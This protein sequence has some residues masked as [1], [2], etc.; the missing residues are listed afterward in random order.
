MCVPPWPNS[1]RFASLHLHL[2]VHLSVSGDVVPIRNLS[3]FLGAVSSGGR[4]RRGGEGIGQ[5]L[6]N[7]Q[8]PGLALAAFGGHDT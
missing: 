6:I 2:R 3:H 4:R 8:F 7:K 1:T 5:L